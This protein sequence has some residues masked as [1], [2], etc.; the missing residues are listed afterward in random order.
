MDISELVKIMSQ[1]RGEKGCPWDREQTPESLK[2]FIIEEAYEVLEAIDEKDPDAIREEL[3]DLLFQIVFQC[4][5]A[6][7]RGEYAL[8]DVVEGVAKKMVRRHP[9]VFWTSSLKTSDEVIASWDGHKQREGKQR[10]SIFEGVPLTLPGLLR[11]RK[12]Q[13]RASKVG[14]DWER[15]GD[16]LE[17]LDEEVEEFKKA[18]SEDNADGIED[19]LGDILFTLVNLSRFVGVNPEEALRKT[20]SKFILRFRKIEDAAKQQG[21]ELRD[22]S[23]E[24]MDAIWDEAKKK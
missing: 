20:I 1:L 9:H 8:P 7:E 4:Q 14:F 2:P 3:G 22:M 10:D 17:K 18:F 11:A 23:L 19:E 21:R 6:S 12:L 16:V 24:E 13:S 5:I 15:P